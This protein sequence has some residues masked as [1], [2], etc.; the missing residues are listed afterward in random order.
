MHVFSSYIV[1][2]RDTFSMEASLLYTVHTPFEV[3]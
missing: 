2:K 1:I 3:D